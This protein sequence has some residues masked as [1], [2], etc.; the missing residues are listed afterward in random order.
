[1]ANIIGSAVGTQ[2][3]FTKQPGATYQKQLAGVESSA[4]YF[5]GIGARGRQLA[6]ALGLLGDAIAQYGEDS[7]ERQKKIATRAEEIANAATPEDFET[8]STISMLSESDVAGQ[9]VDNPWAVA[10]IDKARGRNHNAEMNLAYNDLVQKEGRLDNWAEEMQRYREFAGKYYSEHVGTATN[11]VGYNAGYFATMQEDTLNQASAAQTKRNNEMTW[12]RDSHF[13]ASLDESVVHWN[14]KKEEESLADIHRILGEYKTAGGTP[15]KIQSGVATL[16]NNLAKEGKLS[17]AVKKAIGSEDILTNWDGSRIPISDIM[18]MNAL[19]PVNVKGQRNALQQAQI[20]TEKSI[21]SC[22]TI[23]ELQT[24][25]NK[26]PWADQ[27]AY[28]PDFQKRKD[29]IDKLEQMKIQQLAQ[30]QDIEY[31]QRS[32]MSVCWNALAGIRDGNGINVPTSLSDLKKTVVKADGSTKE[33]AVTIDEMKEVLMTYINQEISSNDNLTDKDKAIETLRLLNH[34]LL[35]KV[36]KA[37]DTTILDALERTDSKDYGSPLYS[38]AMQAVE[39]IRNAPM[40]AQR[41]MSSKTYA[42][43]NSLMMLQDIFPDNYMDLFAQSRS[44]PEDARK[45]YKDESVEDLKAE[46]FTLH[47][48]GTMDET[49][50]LYMDDPEYQ[51]M[52]ATTMVSLRGAGLSREAAIEQLAKRFDMTYTEYDGNYM[53]KALFQNYATDREN[54]GIQFMDSQKEAYINEQMVNGRLVDE[55]SL[56]WKWKPS[57]GELWLIDND[58]PGVIAR[59]YTC[60]EFVDA[61]NKWGEEQY[62]KQQQAEEEQTQAQNQMAIEYTNRV[63]NA[64][65]EARKQLAANGFENTTYADL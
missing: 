40:Q 42:M 52:F 37:Y 15:E 60:D 6:Q 30:A 43:A 27:M 17:D 49:Q 10:L 59:R 47:S 45:V 35:S 12:Q 44:L 11:E 3:Q 18:S 36:A 7:I 13:L 41:I 54:V 25:Y 24:L 16:L 65:E 21:R 48:L 39:M 28:Q 55:D 26:L 62:A 61:T 63:E 53:P 57:V 34:P 1:M 32:T 51:D 23:T 33:E 5:N 20:D 58:N 38:T 19:D 31:N 56:Q 29:E 14:E 64:R 8:R 4:H 2:R 9:L 50:A 46:S 22:T